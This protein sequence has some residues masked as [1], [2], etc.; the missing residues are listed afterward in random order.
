M[1][2]ENRATLDRLNEEVLRQGNVDAVDE[3]MA[4]DFVEHDPPPGMAADRDGFKDFIRG[5]HKAFADQLHTVHDQIADGDRVVERWTMTATHAD[6]FLGI[7]ATGRRVTLV[8]IDISRVE[9]GR[10]AEHWTQC[11]MLGFLEQLGAVP[12]QEA[13]GS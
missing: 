9:D 8:G 10:I 6:E 1:S 11:D 12:A 5:V 13:V 3:L 4:D 7:P 2:Q